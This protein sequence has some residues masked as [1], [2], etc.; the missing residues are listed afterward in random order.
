[1]R[2]IAS[3]ACIG[4]ALTAMAAKTSTYTLSSPDGKVTTQITA[5]SE[6]TFTAAYGG[7]QLMAPSKIGVLLD[8]GTAVGTDVKVSS[9]KT[10]SVDTR[11]ASP[12]YR[13]DYIADHY[14]QLTLRIGKDWSVE[15]RAYNDGVAYRFVTKTKKPFN[16]VNEIAEFAFT[17]DAVATVPYVNA[18]T[19]GKKG[20]F[21]T[22]FFNSFENTY[23]IAKLSEL[24]TDRLA[25]LPL[26]VEPVKG[27]KILFSEAGITDYPGMYLNA[28]GDKLVGVFAPY[29]KAWKQGGH[30]ELQ[31]LVTESEP[32]IAKANGPKE[33]P[34]RI[35]VV[36]PD[37]KTLAATEL[38]YLLAAPSRVADISW[39]KPGKVAWDWW[40]GWN[41]EG[42]DFE[43][44]INNDTYKAYIDFAS[45]HNIEYVILDEGWA[46]N[47]KADLFQVVPEINLEELVEYGKAK[48]VGLILWAGFYALERDMEHVFKHYSAMGIKGFKVDFFDRDDQIVNEFASRAAAMAADYHMILDLHGFHKGSC[49]N[50][51]YPNVLNVEGVHGLETMKWSDIDTD[52]VTYD[53]QIPFIRQA[54]GP[55]DYTQGAM[56]NGTKMNY[57]RSYYEPMSQGTRCRQLALYMVLD[58]PF[59]MLC[60]APSNYRKE[61]ACTEFIAQVPT[62]WDETVILDGKVGEHIVTARR[63]GNTWY[64]GGLTNWTPRDYELD[65]SF[66]GSGSHTAEIFADGKNAH[67]RGTDFVRKQQ[68]V[69]N[70]DKIK[71]HMAPGGGF[72]I[73]I[74]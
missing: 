5:G 73:K 30:N 23:T 38:T 50:R 24:D 14:N 60:D 46:V 58:S 68:T 64:V 41:I 16:I 66:L 54:A 25:F 18:R 36:A 61:P 47:K 62:V 7:E 11:V 27:K 53:V 70:T 39:I 56:I 32:Y 22:Q 69:S 71:L 4:L 13:S 1:M 31:L 28:Q 10:T 48:N 52:Q 37:D 55:M 17:G 12:F 34:W 26:T 20:D 59:N 3:I 49:M 19:S 65:L 6:L 45:E 74:N 33:L 40:N 43:A 2:I 21:S 35:A 51:T 67:R 72:A 9:A 44:G 63:K 29:P 8:N 15:F 42:V 57:R